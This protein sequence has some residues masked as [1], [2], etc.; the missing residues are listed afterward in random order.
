MQEGGSLACAIDSALLRTQGTLTGQCVKSSTY[1]APSQTTVTVSD[2]QAL[3][4]QFDLSLSDWRWR[5]AGSIRDYKAPGT[6]TSVDC[7]RPSVW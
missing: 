5:T 6:C 1:L 2:Y 7:S 3:H 4:Q